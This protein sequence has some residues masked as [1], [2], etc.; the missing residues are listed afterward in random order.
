MANAR[1]SALTAATTPLAGTEVLPVVQ[2][3]T[4]KQVS[5][6]NLTAGRAVS[7]ASLA[8][9]TAL[10][11]TSGGTGTGTAFTAGSVIFAG[12]SGVYSQ[13]NSKFFWDNTNFRLA[14]GQA[15]A[16]YQFDVLS[17]LTGTAAGDNT[18]AMFSS[19]AS[20]RDANIRFGDTANASARIGYLS[21]D[22]YF[23]VNGQER[24]RFTTG[25]VAQ[26]FKNAT[27][28]NSYVDVFHATGST[29]G[30]SFVNF[31]YNG[32]SIG[33]IAQDGTAAVK[34]NTSS[35]YRLKENVIPMT[36]GLDKVL[37][38]KPVTFNWIDGR[39]GQGF[40]AHELQEVIPDA[41]TGIK[42][43]VDQ[44]G[45]AKYQSVDL[46]RVIATLTL[47]VQELKNEVDALKAQLVA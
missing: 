17:T 26:F 28:V 14:L 38:L 36:G 42:D 34:Y 46:S 32:T 8:L 2:S 27:T 21:G 29:N 13:N 41:V 47:A 18:L 15:S 35:D 22:L 24:V 39:E 25:S 30:S 45:N 44:E 10:P 16:S 37:Q 23:Y 6:A 7:A 19:N 20:G 11:V 3:G 33:D 4:T 9:T 31:R 1:I 12:A 40:I 5:V 43:G